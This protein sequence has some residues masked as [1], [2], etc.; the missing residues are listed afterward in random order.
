M[1]VEP[2][3]G[4]TRV[5]HR[6]APAWTTDWISVEGKRKLSQDKPEADRA[7]VIAALSASGD[8][9]DGALADTMREDE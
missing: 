9:R 6:L 5:T 8:P 4:P 2:T 7:S 1:K 3:F